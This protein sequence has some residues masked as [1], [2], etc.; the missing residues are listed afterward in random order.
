M[1]SY[2]FVSLLALLPLVGCSSSDGGNAPTAPGA[3]PP[4]ATSHPACVISADCPAGEHCDLSECVQD[5]NDSAPCS[6]TSLS[7]S[8]RAR[9]LPQGTPDKDPPP[10]TA[11]A[12]DLKVSPQSVALTEKTKSFDVKLTSTSKD[13]VR[14]RVALNG[15]HLSIDSARGQFTG[16]TTITI[17]VDASKL[18]GQETLGSLKIFT[19]L[20]DAT[21]NA[22]LHAGLTGTYHGS[23]RYDGGAIPL[24]EARLALDLIEKNGDVSARIDSK[25]S[26]LFPATASG[27]TTGHGSFTSTDG[28]DLTVQQLVDAGFGNDANGARNHFGRPIG[29]RVRF[30]LK[31]QGSGTLAGTFTEMIYGLYAEPVRTTGTV[32]LSY[33]PQNADPKFTL[34][35][36][37]VMPSGNS[38]APLTP[39]KVFN[40]AAS[41]S[42]SQMLGC[43]QNCGS[44]LS[45]ME[46]TYYI[47]TLQQAV[48]GQLSLKKNPFDT[49]PDACS[50]AITGT[51][52]AD[53]QPNCGLLAPMACALQVGAHG[54]VADVAT[55]KIVN[56]MVSE[57]LAPA[58]LVAKN[59]IVHALNDSFAGG[60]DKEGPH[61]DTAMAALGP[62]ATWLE[63]PM[64]LEYLRG[65]PGDAARGDVS[66]DNLTRTDTY[67]AARAYA[68][69]FAT[70]AMIDGERARLG[71][72]ASAGRQPA[73]VGAAQHRAVLSLLEAMVVEELLHAWSAAPDSVRGR[74][75][76]MLTPMDRGF[77][78]LLQGANV[79][80]VPTGFVPFVYR[81]E[82]VSKGPTNFEQMIAIAN[83]AVNGE[84]DPENAFTTD[85]RL[86]EA[87][88]GKVQ[89]ELVSIQ[90]T[91]DMQLK[92]TCGAAF[93]P[94]AITS[95]AD[96]SRLCTGGDI[97][98]LQLEIQGA[99]A[100]VHSAQTR[101]SGMMQKIQIDTSALAEKQHVHDEEIAFISSTGDQL[102]S[103]A[104]QQEMWTATQQA[105]AQSS[106]ILD[107]AES[108]GG[109]FIA[110]AADIAIGF[111][112]AGLAEQQVYLQTA[113]SMHA[114]QTSKELEYIDG[115]ANIQKELVDL[116]Q[117]NVDIEQDLLGATEAALKVQ[118][119]LANA[120]L[121]LEQRARAKAVA[122]KDPTNDP[123]FR[124]LRDQNALLAIQAR[125]D[126][127]KQ[128][129]LAA[130]AL[131]YELNMS[132]DGIDGAV[133][134]AHDAVSLGALSNC[135]LEIYNQSR[136]AYGTP[137]DYVTT[138]SVRKMLGVSG[139][140]KD[141]VTGQTLSEGDQF[142]QLVLKN[143]NI[144]GKGGV[145]IVFTTNLEPGNGLWSG[146]VCSDKLAS[147]Q[148][149]LVG[150]FLGDNQAQVNIMLEGGALLRSCDSD[151]LREWSFG[152]A[153]EGG[154]LASAVIQAGV[155]TFGDAPPN[156]SLFGQ[157][158]ARA[159]WT[160]VIPG[161][162]DAP[163]NA[164]VDL[165]HL[166]DVVL[167]FTHKAQPRRNSP[168]SIDLS[169]LSR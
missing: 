50:K 63:Q 7:C 15:P 19:T 115:M 152:A 156:T 56:R 95:D 72:A 59:E 169:C 20:G 12:G 38:V 75:L 18:A 102:A 158:V 76:G 57:T 110:S 17:K 94:D 147:V 162:A 81:P 97:A 45:A 155:N 117:A 119:A 1:R 93:D 61:Y 146:D 8:P 132:V 82:D 44:L 108:F 34:G 150:D 134:R 21:I 28:L 2:R 36:D 77:A 66:S 113:Q 31:P 96:W 26:L 99:R 87:A 111:Q 73:L 48:D 128:L 136:Y 107:D 51:S 10:V 64:F 89:S 103:I 130:H 62:I 163:A 33:V 164:D 58:L 154:S 37:P 16:S 69:L 124:V 129:Y 41:G 120:K 84:K 67:P 109:N 49:L 139:P 70:M 4:A 46:G 86:Y 47:N 112:K 106:N 144:D 168:V 143:E 9:C 141:D 104:F 98:V 35:P 153:T 127:Q 161:G 165:T 145:G 22:P 90:G 71:A 80:G 85:K 6:D 159:K 105:I 11:H 121:L 32:Q 140:R 24:G 142:R 30:Q 88:T 151:D 167:K 79:Y 25:T 114:Q 83:V 149:Q 133:M 43:S 68:D 40:W 91:Y 148:A 101:I 138:V 42:C 29:R 74:F 65:L 100:R 92:Q 78:S 55:A 131:E 118:N 126:A 157:S 160:L 125:D 116:A 14:Y 39:D 27:E 23:M 54:S 135:L 166:D 52:N 60:A 5:C 123:S 53:F 137:Q 122:L 13:P 3:P